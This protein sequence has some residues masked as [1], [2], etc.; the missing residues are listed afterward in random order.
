LTKAVQPVA[1]PR[2]ARISI[3]EAAIVA[4]CPPATITR[5]IATHVLPSSKDRTIALADALRFRDL[6]WSSIRSSKGKG[7]V[8]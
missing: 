6:L 7:V 8:K 3:A 5:A 2:P 4:N 1:D